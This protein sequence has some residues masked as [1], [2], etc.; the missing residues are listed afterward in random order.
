M[1][2]FLSFLFIIVV[3]A[4]GNI[5]S[6]HADGLAMH[7]RPAL[8]TNFHHFPYAAPEAP[9][10]GKITFGVVGTFDGLN[11]FVVKGT[12]TT[13]RGL[14]NDEQFG[15]LV[16]EGFMVR[17]RDE[18]FTL[19]SLLAEKV[20]MNDE[21][22]AITFYLNPH[23][24]FS[25]GAPVTQDDVFFTID[26]L[27]EQGRPPF[28]SYLQTIERIEKIGTHGVRFHL[29]PSANR[30][31]PLIL[32]SIIPILPKH[33]VNVATFRDNGFTVIPGTGPY[34]IDNIKPGE[35]IIYRRNSDYWGKDLPVN[36]GLYNFDI[37]QVEYY[38]N[39]NARFEAFKKG[40]L[41]VF[42][43]EPANPNRWAQGYDFPAEREG[44]VIKE[45]FKK[46]TPAAM[47][48]FVFNTRKPIFSDVRVRR[49]LS[50]TLDFEWINRNLFHNAYQRTNGYWDNSVLSSINNP[51]NAKEQALLAPFPDTVLPD[52]MEGIWRAPHTD[53]SGF[54]RENLETA[55][56][57]L[58]DAGFSRKGMK[59]YTP[60]GEQ[61]RFEIMTL[62]GDEERIALAF[63]RSLAR[64][65]VEVSV[66]T[67]DD[68]QYQTRLSNFDYDMI[69]RNLSASLSPGNEQFN[70]WASSSCD[71]EGSFNYA[72]AHDRAIDAMIKA[73]T[74][75][76]SMDDFVAAVRALDRIL[77]SG[78]YF[79]P[80][81][82]LPNQ[83][84][85]RWNTVQ[86]PD[87]TSLYGY[88]IST[89]W[90]TDGEG[91]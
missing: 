46:G 74:N 27:R 7:G 63:Q 60:E 43:E 84:V 80:L 10:G 15:S 67:V 61:F 50:M 86:H 38:R 76:R 89:W 59:V 69:I 83:W 56:M 51:A 12:R 29:S 19:Y 65:G 6:G 39:Q 20:E 11:P 21:R 5:S 77:I 55:W 49:A 2:R 91:Q 85:A 68:T 23:A 16:Y 28:S 66:R 41:D 48:G 36:R 64:L 87:Y 47:T 54:D 3:A 31:L 24:R 44:K 33:A 30:E 53:S 90:H 9:K 18:P 1:I 58:Q 57:I 4:S 40:I 37:F 79:I 78:N 35:R 62:S 73:M 26:L 72:G 13:A 32:A 75:A 8:P 52:V 42:I 45:S 82:H 88:R 81:Y 34:I 25:D 17:S 71:V 22:T 14:F 70:R